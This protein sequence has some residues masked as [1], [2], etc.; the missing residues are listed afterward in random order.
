M[1]EQTTTTQTPPTNQRDSKGVAANIVKGIQ[2]KAGA[3]GQQK[4]PPPGNNAPETAPDPNQGKEKYT[5]NGQDV[6]L[7]PEQR[8]AWIQKGMAFEPK[9]TQLNQLQNEMGSFFQTLVND[10]LKI[11]TD[12]RIGMTPE[13]VM[14]KIFNSGQISDGLKEKVGR[15]Y[16]E[17]VVQVERMT[18][19]QKRARQLE[20]ENAQYKTKEQKAADAAIELENKRKIE[21]AFSQL[22]SQIAEAMKDSGLP[23]NDT[24]LGAE[25]AR[26]VADVMRIARFQR[27][28]VT[29]KQAIEKVRARIKEVQSM[30]Y[31]SLDEEALVKEI[32]EANAEK[33]KK[34]F[35]KLAKA[36]GNEP[37]KSQKSPS[38]PRGERKTMN[39]DDFREYLEK[40]KR[41][42]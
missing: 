38:T 40:R 31:D 13:I 25:M 17:N 4:A 24:P 36:A 39:E 1:S 3:N 11:L 35:L 37:P 42:G 34:Y 22:K 6:W 16:W 32:G 23:S 7:T 10:P 15:W 14:E 28:S 2:N 9:V 5:V 27:Q 29:P 12:K 19:E 26:M 41:E 33:V 21:L 8:T 18:P 30:F 20:I